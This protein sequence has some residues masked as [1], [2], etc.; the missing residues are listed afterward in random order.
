MRHLEQTH[1][2]TGLARAICH[3]RVQWPRGTSTFRIMSLTVMIVA[4]M[5]LSQVNV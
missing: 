2:E 1:R 3:A 5:C 4:A